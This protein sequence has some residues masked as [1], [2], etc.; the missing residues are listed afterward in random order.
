MSASKPYLL[1][2]FLPDVEVGRVKELVHFEGDVLGV[3][4]EPDFQPWIALQGFLVRGQTQSF[5]SPLEIDNCAG[6][7]GMDSTVGPG[8]K[9]TTFEGKLG[10]FV[11]QPKS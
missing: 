8:K 2:L 3:E 11:P 5:L 1:N 4:E 7:R 9:W 6:I 10:F